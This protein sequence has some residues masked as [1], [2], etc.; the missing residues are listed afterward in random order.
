MLSELV[1]LPNLPGATN[2]MLDTR[3]QR[4]RNNQTSGRI[5]QKVLRNGFLFFRHTVSN[6]TGF[7]PTGLP[8]SGSLSA[9]RAQHATLA[10]THSSFTPTMVNEFKLGFARLRLE[11]LSENAFKRDIVSELGIP[12]VQFGGP[13]VWGIPSV[14]IPGYS[15][16]G[17]DNFFLPMRLR[18]NTYQVLDTLA[19]NRGSHNFRL[20]GESR[21]FQFNYPDFHASRR[22]PVQL[23]LHDANCRRRIGR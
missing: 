5:D 20:G 3:N 15:A 1:P 19:W 4:Q 7:V 8:G 16:I 2:N 22:L 14:T 18:N 11:R 9:V 21:R 17:D 6:E 13:Q 23:E 10:E 12:G